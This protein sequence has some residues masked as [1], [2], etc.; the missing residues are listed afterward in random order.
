MSIKEMESKILNLEQ[1]L[2][3]LASRPYTQRAEEAKSEATK[4]GSKEEADF[5]QA[6]SEI[7]DAA[8]TMADFI[9]DLMED[10]YLKKKK[11][12]NI[13]VEVVNVYAIMKIIIKSK[14]KTDEYCFT[15][16]NM[17]H[18]DIDAL[19]NEQY[20]ELYQLTIKLYTK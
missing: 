20:E 3:A 12:E 18:F 10:Y 4:V 17:F 19:T 8:V 7:V 13:D 11:E 5:N 9:T 2:I 6:S 15:K 14:K 16:L 1:Q